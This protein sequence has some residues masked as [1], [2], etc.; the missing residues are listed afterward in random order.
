MADRVPEP[1]MEAFLTDYN[2]YRFDE[3]LGPWKPYVD[4]LKAS[5]ERT[6][7][8][9]GVPFREEDGQAIYDAVPTWGPH[10]DVPAP[11]KRVAARIPLVIL[12]N[13]ANTQIMRNV[14]L[15]EA[16][17]HAVCT[18]EQAQAYKPRFKAFEYMFDTLGCGPEDVLH[19]SASY[20]YD[21]T[22]AYG[23]RIAHR[24]YINRG[25]EP[26]I[27]EYGAHQATTIEGLAQLVG[28]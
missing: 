28:V 22:P 10:P 9:H 17:F 1:Q 19:V 16:P 6:C 8:R 27:P 3:V 15:L 21:L 14:A 13:A 23:L 26:V 12:S 18:A 7:R 24:L 4:V 5:L 25:Y 11:L 2:W 20:R